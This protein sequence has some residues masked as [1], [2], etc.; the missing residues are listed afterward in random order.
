MKYPVFIYGICCFIFIALHT[1]VQSQI[2][3]AGDDFE[4]CS[5]SATLQANNPE[6][7]NGYWT[8]EAGNAIITHSNQHITTVYN[9]YHGANTFRWTVV[10]P[11]TITYDL[12]T[13]TN[14]SLHAH[15]Y[16]SDTVYTDASEMELEA[17]LPKNT[18]GEWSIVNSE[19]TIISSTSAKTTFTNLNYCLNTFR[20]TITRGECP[21]AKDIVVIRNY[22]IDLGDDQRICESNTR[23]QV[24][25][26]ANKPGKWEVVKGNGSFG[27]YENDEIVECADCDTMQNPVLYNISQGENIVR[28][29]MTYEPGCV[30]KKELRITNYYF[31]IEAGNNIVTCEN[32]V[33]M[34]AEKAALTG[35][36]GYGEWNVVSGTGNVE[37]DVNNTEVTG[38]SPGDNVLEW[39]V[40]RYATGNWEG[41]DAKDTVMVTYYHLPK[42]AIGADVQNGCTPLNVQLNSQIVFDDDAKN[43]FTW[44]SSKGLTIGEESLEA[45]YT[46]TT[47]QTLSYPVFLYAKSEYDDAVCY[48]TAHINIDVYALP[49]ASLTIS[50]RKLVYPNRTVVLEYE[51]A[52]CLLE[53]N[54]GDGTTETGKLHSHVYNT[55][56]EMDKDFKYFVTLT[57]NNGNCTDSVSDFVQILPE[58]L[59]VPEVSAIP[60]QSISQCEA[61]Q[62]INLL[63]YADKNVIWNT[64]YSEHFIVRINEGT[65]YIA[66]KNPQWTGSETIRF[67]AKYSFGTSSDTDVT[68]TVSE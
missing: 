49:K 36:I 21:A 12:I 11:Q 42:A 25:S 20:W 34:Q 65:A 50:P 28:R 37:S 13:V 53:W 6:T 31:E 68:F 39:H 56:G 35:I 62:P 1:P 9:L 40:T 4:T 45:T 29:I 61:F 33:K 43:T 5:S 57:V 26:P 51:C 41:C 59:P 46:N 8:L 66:Q 19:A 47:S 24:V 60:N 67:T 10:A 7:G 44:N 18:K 52:D 14:N 55:W 22:P 17:F 32:T 2:A 27:K 58:Q 54:F 63:D 15:I 3:D 16:A 48:D 23:L 38:V 30:L 64:A